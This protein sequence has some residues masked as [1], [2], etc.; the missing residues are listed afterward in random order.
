MIVQALLR[1]WSRTPPL[2]RT[3]SKNGVLW[4]ESEC[5]REYS[6]KEKRIKENKSH[7]TP[8]SSKQKTVLGMFHA[9]PRC[10]GFHWLFLCLHGKPC[11]ISGGFSLWLYSLNSGELYSDDLN[12]Q[13]MNYQR[14]WIK[15]PITRDFSILKSNFM[16]EGF[17]SPGVFKYT[18]GWYD[19]VGC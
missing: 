6:K 19:V 11:C 3:Q 7:M 2:V 17:R 10:S 8:I 9:P 16:H 1:K 5:L 13:S 4:G 15:L 12:P 14:L 18:T